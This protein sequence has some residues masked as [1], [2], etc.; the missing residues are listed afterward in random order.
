M[1]RHAVKRMLDALGALMCLL[2]LWPLLGGIALAVRLDSP[3]GA[4]FRQIRLGRGGRRFTMLKFRTMRMDS[5]H[6]GSGVYSNGRDDRVTRVGR[7]L[8][9]TSLDELPQLWNILRGDMSFVGPRPPLTYHPWPLADYTDEQKR[10]FAVRPGLTG[11]A[12]VNG[13]RAVLWP[14]R[15]RLHI[16]Y[17]D[18]LSPWLDIRILICTVGRVISGRDNENHT[19]TAPARDP[20]QLT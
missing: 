18:H 9:R 1:Y 8:R 19:E 2:L 16:W 17:V 4:I 10:M 5:E 3:G 15:I 14:E 11:W 6:E 7:F 12:Q 20:S 13:R